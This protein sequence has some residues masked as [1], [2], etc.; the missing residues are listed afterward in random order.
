MDVKRSV[1]SYVIFTTISMRLW[2]CPEFAGVVVVVLGVLGSVLLSV[3]A[4][5]LV[6]VVVE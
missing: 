3:F 5:L 1:V 4:L 2:G 6:D